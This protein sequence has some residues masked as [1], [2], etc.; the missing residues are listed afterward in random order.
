MKH[1]AITLILLS[2]FFFSCKESKNKPE[3][4]R[5]SLTPTH[6]VSDSIESMMPGELL[7]TEDYIIWSDPFHSDYFVHVLDKTS[8]KEIGKIGKKGQGPTEFITPAV[9]TRPNN[10]LFISDLNSDKTGIFSIPQSIQDDQ[11][12]V[13]GKMEKE[14]ITSLLFSNSDEWISFS[15]SLSIPFSFVSSK[16]T[17]SFGKLPIEGDISQSIDHFQGTIAYHPQK[18]VFVYSTLKFPYFTIYKKKGDSFEQTKEVFFSDEY[19]V[20]D[21]VFSYQGERMGAKGLALTSKYI[22][23]LERDREFDKTDERKVGRDFTKLSHTVFLYNYD[24]QLEKI[25]DLGAPV[26]RLAADPKTNALYA[27]IVNPDFMLV[28]CEL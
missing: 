2:V 19:E 5:I 25:V 23:A 3:V 18:N 8:G 13:L 24:L 27:I 10:E 4:E 22:V 6:I 15:P 21:G 12:F 26:L 20:K 7:L 16:G 9:V 28:K 14:D 1:N 11:N 17:K